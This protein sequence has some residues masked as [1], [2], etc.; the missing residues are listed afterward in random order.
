MG[1]FGAV[2]PGRTR[3]RTT[4]SSHAAHQNTHRPPAARLTPGAAHR[5][6]WKPFIEK[7]R[8]LMLALAK[9]AEKMEK[10]SGKMKQARQ[11]TEPARAATNPEDVNFRTIMR[12][13]GQPHIQLLAAGMCH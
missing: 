12:A 3:R 11:Q 7:A 13:T 1:A 9:L 2:R 8:E 4:L 5:G 10:K 6:R